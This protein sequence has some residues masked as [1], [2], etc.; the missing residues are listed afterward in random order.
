[1]IILDTNVVSE[2]MRPG[3]N[4]DVRKWIDHNSDPADVYTTSI[5]AAELLYGAEKLPDGRRK[6]VLLAKVHDFLHR[7]IGGQVFAFT[8]EAAP[9][10]ADIITI[11]ERLGR[12][13]SLFDGQIA[14][15]CRLLGAE[16]ATR[17]VEDFRYTGVTIV[18][19]WTADPTTGRTDPVGP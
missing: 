7:V 5:T 12:P 3:S 11:R 14:A 6:V 18:N 1:M 15:I 4:P 10:F 8:A 19:P 2:L 16:L 17:N 9:H 13:I